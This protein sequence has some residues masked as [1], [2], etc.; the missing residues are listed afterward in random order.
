[1][2]AAELFVDDLDSHPTR[3]AARVLDGITA[4]VQ[5]DALARPKLRLPDTR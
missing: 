3:M 5:L 2:R 1:V 4:T